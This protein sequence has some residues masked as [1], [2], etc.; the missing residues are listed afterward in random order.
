M[1]RHIIIITR[2]SQR[3]I[4]FLRLLDQIKLGPWYPKYEQP[5]KVLIKLGIF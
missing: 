1:A 5:W 4:N 2:G 3:Q